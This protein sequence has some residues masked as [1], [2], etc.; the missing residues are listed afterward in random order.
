M[1]ESRPAA[2]SFRPGYARVIQDPSHAYGEVHWRALT[3]R[4]QVVGVPD[5]NR[6]VNAPRSAHQS[7]HDVFPEG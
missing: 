5:A 3:G 2:P 6:H 7:T 1:E 4:P